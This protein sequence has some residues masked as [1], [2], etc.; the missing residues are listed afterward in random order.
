MEE[1]T[2]K[3]KFAYQTIANM[4]LIIKD[5][6]LE[7]QLAEDNLMY[8]L[9]HNKKLLLPPTLKFKCQTV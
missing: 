7:S 4:E 5:L 8:I 3:L 6:K 2:G 9:K 1:T